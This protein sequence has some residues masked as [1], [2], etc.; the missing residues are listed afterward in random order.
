MAQT[1][2]HSLLFAVRVIHSVVADG[3]GFPLH[4]IAA[5]NDRDHVAD[6]GQGLQAHLLIRRAMRLIAIIGSRH[7][8][9]AGRSQICKCPA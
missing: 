2:V 1:T 9:R 3:G 5:A 7:P 4:L 8:I 6:S